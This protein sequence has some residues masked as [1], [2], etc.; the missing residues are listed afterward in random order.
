M[1]YTGPRLSAPFRTNLVYVFLGGVHFSAF[2]HMHS[3]VFL[4]R[5]AV[6]ILR[7]PRLH[8]PLVPAVGRTRTGY[9]FTVPPTVSVRA[10]RVCLHTHDTRFGRTMYRTGFCTA[11]GRGAGAGEGCYITNVESN[12]AEGE[13]ERVCEN[14]E[15]TTTRARDSHIPEV[16]RKR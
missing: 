5:C 14:G 16:A 1:V 7:V 13:T 10:Y 4:A 6:H 8:N 3:P 15:E 2:A 12:Q 11:Q 9:G